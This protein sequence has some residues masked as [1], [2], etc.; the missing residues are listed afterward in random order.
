MRC[1]PLRHD[2][3]DLAARQQLGQLLGTLRSVDVHVELR[4]VQHLQIQETDAVEVQAP[5]GRTQPPL[6]DQ[7]VEVFLDLFN[8]QLVRC[9]PEMPGK[10]CHSAQIGLVRPFGITA[11]DHQIQHL[12]A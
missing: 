6:P 9:G 10:A 2:L 4:P 1:L 11:L 7:V 12:L 5:A 8:M 3:F